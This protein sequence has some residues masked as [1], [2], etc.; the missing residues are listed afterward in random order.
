MF[1]FPLEKQVNETDC[2]PC[3][4]LSLL[5]YHGGDGSLVEMRARCRT[6]RSGTRLSDLLEAAEHYGFTTR[7]ARGSLQ[8]LAEENLPCIAHVILNSGLHH[9]LIILNIGQNKV[10]VADPGKSVHS[11][12]HQN[13]LSIWK[14]GI[15]LL[16]EPAGPLERKA[17]PGWFQWIR[18][19]LANTSSWLVQSVVLALFLSISGLVTALLI[20][21]AIDVYIPTANFHEFLPL[22]AFFAIVMLLRALAGNARIR[23]LA[24]FSE[25][26]NLELHTDF[27]SQLLAL[28][29]HFFESRKTGDLTARMQDALRIQ[30]AVVQ[31]C[32]DFLIQGILLLS[33]LGY[34]IIMSPGI[35][36]PVCGLLLLYVF[37]G[38]YFIPGLKTRNNRLMKSYAD[39]ESSYIDIIHGQE[40]IRRNGADHHFN[41]KNHEYFRQF[42]DL[43]KNLSIFAA[44]Y[45]MSIEGLSALLSILFLFL[46]VR[47]VIQGKLPLGQFMGSYSLLAGMIPALQLIMSGIG[48]LQQA[49]IAY[50][51]LRDILLHPSEKQDG[52]QTFHDQATSLRVSGLNFSYPKSPRLFHHVTFSLENN[53]LHFLQ[54]RNGSGKSTLSRLLCG[55]YTDYQGQILLN[56]CS[57]KNLSIEL[58]RAAVRLIPQDIYIFNGTLLENI[59]IGLGNRPLN[60]LERFFK[61]YDFSWFI[62]RFKLGLMTLLS[63]EGQRLSGGEK[64]IIGL[65]RALLSQPR[66]L[67]VDEGI[68]SL[69]T[70]SR[71][72]IQA[73]LENYAATHLVLIISHDPALFRNN[74]PCIT[75][76]DRHE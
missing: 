57:L 48:D 4:L 49:R 42:Q 18:P 37:T 21:Q 19:R 22:L 23:M 60:E 31:V 32:N 67:I 28:P 53:G 72:L 44:D 65:I 29:Q 43:R 55:I 69:D 33:S 40:S 5:R 9:Y 26:F 1:R 68:S 8:E 15:V 75:I 71:P 13:F 56:G 46:G 38:I 74:T 16:L 30:R 14:E 63:E 45:G 24:S 20:Q 73:L 25:R 17:P 51:R 3:C 10:K 58:L 11:L 64:F 7:A 41:M 2:G 59:Q 47:E 52:L 12:S 50:V 39:L 34:M 27:I 66:L 54:G 76:G 36:V 6:D 70:E 62:G 35:V 61:S